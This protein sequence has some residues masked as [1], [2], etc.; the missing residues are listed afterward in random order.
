MHRLWKSILGNNL[1]RK[2]GVKAL[3][4]PNGYALSPIG[5]TEVFIKKILPFTSTIGISIRIKGRFKFVNGGNYYG[6][7]Y[8]A[9]ILLPNNYL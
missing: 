5:T 1:N 2:A 3:A 8:V 7:C 4:F 9:Q 6:R